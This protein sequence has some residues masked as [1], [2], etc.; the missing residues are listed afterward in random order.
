MILVSFDVVNHFSNRDDFSL[1][2]SVKAH[3]KH[4]ISLMATVDVSVD[5]VVSSRVMTAAALFCKNILVI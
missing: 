4:L 2:F 1:K 3:S 5:V